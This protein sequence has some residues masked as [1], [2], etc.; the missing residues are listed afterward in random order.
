MFFYLVIL[1]RYI[2]STIWV[3]VYIYIILLPSKI[4]QNG[5]V[6]FV[7][8]TTRI[9]SRKDYVGL[10]CVRIYLKYLSISLW[11]AV[12]FIVMFVWYIILACLFCENWSFEMWTPI[13]KR[14][15]VLFDIIISYMRVSTSNI[16]IKERLSSSYISNPTSI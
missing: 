9:R 7:D 8:C 13:F 16:T 2:L 14:S 12:V 3:C 15:P 1:Y 5:S 4:N 6:S 10:L 11:L